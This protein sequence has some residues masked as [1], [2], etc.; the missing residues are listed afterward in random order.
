MKFKALQLNFDE[1]IQRIR[2][3]IQALLFEFQKN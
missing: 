3:E 1:Y 2:F